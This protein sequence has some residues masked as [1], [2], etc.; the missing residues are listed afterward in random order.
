VPHPITVRVLDLV[1]V[2]APIASEDV[3]FSSRP[4]PLR[5]EAHGGVGAVSLVVHVAFV[6]QDRFQ[7][8]VV[9]ER[10]DA[11]AQ[12]G[13]RLIQTARPSLVAIRAKLL[14]DPGYE[15]NVENRGS[16]S[17]VS[18]VIWIPLLENR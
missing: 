13:A 16:N 10:M 8:L 4:L 9:G 5:Q 7:T 17:L 2:C 11:V 3:A 14:G 12:R 6:A 15:S 1:H 18:V